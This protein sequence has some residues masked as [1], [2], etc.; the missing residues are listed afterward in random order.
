[1][2]IGAADTSS[3]DKCVSFVIGSFESIMKIHK[4]LGF[5]NIHMRDLE[6][7]E[8]KLVIHR[9]EIK[10][11]VRIVCF[12]V[13]RH[14]I[15]NRLQRELES[16]MRKKGYLEEHFNRALGLQI[17]FQ[18]GSFVASH[19]V[20]LE[21]INFECDRDMKRTLSYLGFQC[22]NPSITHELADVTAYCNGKNISMD[23]LIE[24]NVAPNIEREIRRQTGL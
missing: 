24:R 9:M 1:M 2:F 23:K 5:T 22:V 16:R 15:I 17:N 13:N 19:S 12:H 10:G 7:R 4:K 8:K 11:D 3:N 18:Y 20:N 14:E 21:S 6:M